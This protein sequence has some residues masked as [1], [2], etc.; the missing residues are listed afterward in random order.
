MSPANFT[1]DAL[2]LDDFCPP[3]LRQQGKV[4]YKQKPLMALIA[5]ATLDAAVGPQAI[6]DWGL[7]DAK[8]IKRRFGWKKIPSASTIRIKLIDL[9]EDA[10]EKWIREVGSRLI[11]RSSSKK[12][13]EKD[14]KQK[15]AAPPFNV[16]AMDG[17]T[18]RRCHASG[19]HAVHMLG[20]ID[21]AERI[22][23]WQIEIGEKENEIT[24]ALELLSHLPLRNT[25][26]TSDAMHTQTKTSEAICGGGGHYIQIAKGN[27]N[28]LYE[29]IRQIFAP[30]P[31]ESP[32]EKNEKAWTR[33]T[34]KTVEKGHGRIEVRELTVT[35]ELPWDDCWPHAKQ[36]FEERRT[37]TVQGKTTTE[38]SYGITDM[39]EK[40][41]DAAGLLASTRAHWNVESWHWQL[42][43]NFREDEL[44]IQNRKGAA[45]MCRFLRLACAIH[46]HGQAAGASG[47][48]SVRSEKYFCGNSDAC[49]KYLEHS[50]KPEYSASRL[51]V[52]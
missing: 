8:R 14:K 31:T 20:A 7:A 13:K 23:L 34:A 15:K 2:A 25:I 38:V 39:S 48:R 9:D 27:Q 45:N 44:H 43:M 40:E 37:R 4:T 49:M 41:V 30:D 28:T 24:R 29:G 42:D 52:N 18:A 51:L 6:H 26:V 11:S 47:T 46:I 21:A 1:W 50:V 22:P 36:C 3:D 12:R 35:T 17:K 19:K 5:M 32:W 33:Q 16:I 10:M